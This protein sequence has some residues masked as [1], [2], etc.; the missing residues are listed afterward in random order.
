VK[1]ILFGG[2]FWPRDQTQV[3]RM[4]GRFFTV[5]ATQEGCNGMVITNT[6]SSAPET[7]S[8]FLLFCPVGVFWTGEQ[9]PWGGISLCNTWQRWSGGHRMETLENLVSFKI[10][11]KLET[12]SKKVLHWPS[13]QG[14]R[15]YRL[16]WKDP[17]LKYWLYHFPIFINS[18]L[19]L[20]FTSSYFSLQI[21]NKFLRMETIQLVLFE[22]GKK[23]WE[24]W[25][26]QPANLS[27]NLVC[28]IPFHHILFLDLHTIYG[29]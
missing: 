23:G 6:K 7:R 25:I 29:I 21:N 12:E 4:V 26:N 22:G 17:G 28:L 14:V 5:W 20:L 2:S 27:F 1:K 15:I 11:P 13:Q 9:N 8:P 18:S 10:L 19:L 24:Q 16:G 3:S